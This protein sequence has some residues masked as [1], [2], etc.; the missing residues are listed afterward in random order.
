VETLVIAL[1]AS[2]NATTGQAGFKLSEATSGLNFLTDGEQSL[3][4]LK[5]G[6]V[7]IGVIDVRNG[8]IT[9]TNGE[10]WSLQ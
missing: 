4:D 6:E 1:N 10:F 9:F 3:I 7:K 2:Q 5:K 8:R